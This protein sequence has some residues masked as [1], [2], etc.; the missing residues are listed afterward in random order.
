MIRITD[1]EGKNV[2]GDGRVRHEDFLSAI[3]RALRYLSQHDPDPDFRFFFENLVE[4]SSLKGKALALHCLTR[5]GEKETINLDP[6][7]SKLTAVNPGD[8]KS[9]SKTV[10]KI[11]CTLYKFRQNAR[12]LWHDR[13][14]GHLIKYAILVMDEAFLA[15]RPVYCQ[16]PH[17][18]IPLVRVRLAQFFVAKDLV[19]AASANTTLALPDKFPGIFTCV[20]PFSNVLVEKNPTLDPFSAILEEKPTWWEVAARAAPLPYRYKNELL[21]VVT[22]ASAKPVA[23]KYSILEGGARLHGKIGLG[24]ARSDSMTHLDYRWAGDLTLGVAMGLRPDKYLGQILFVPPAGYMES[25]RPLHINI[26]YFKKFTA[27][28]GRKNKPFDGPVYCLT[29]WS[30]PAL[31][32]NQLFHRLFGSSLA[33]QRKKNKG[34]DRKGQEL[35]APTQDRQSAQA[36]MS[37]KTATEAAG[38]VASVWGKYRSVASIIP[39]SGEMVMSRPI[40]PTDQEWCHLIGHGDGGTETPENFVAGSK[41]CNTEQLAI[42]CALRFDTELHNKL[43]ARVTAYVPPETMTRT[44]PKPGMC[45]E[46]RSF[47]YDQCVDREDIHAIVKFGLKK[48]VPESGGPFKWIKLDMEPPGIPQDLKT[49]RAALITSISAKIKFVLDGGNDISLLDSDIKKLHAWREHKDTY[50]QLSRIADEIVSKIFNMPTVASFIR[51][52]VRLGETIVYDRIYDAQ[53]ESIDR[54]E[55]M[56]IYEDVRAALCYAA[57]RWRA[58]E[59]GRSATATCPHLL[60]AACPHGCRRDARTWSYICVDKERSLTVDNELR[61]GLKHAKALADAEAAGHL[62]PTQQPARMTR[63]EVE[64]KQA[65]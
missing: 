32:K 28:T 7:K 8:D 56:I 41:H 25:P 47:D 38:E 22:T 58:G 44:K 57:D 31:V 15:Q 36:V 55:F 46:G 27:Q 12:V 65:P 2:I 23:W 3:G 18:E 52:Q 62:P 64:T 37:Q 20:D 49:K 13:L 16:E 59:K 35:K 19:K 39:G 1:A 29:N 10:S 30:N 61:I 5:S 11:T 24:I 40:P 48:A 60:G 34:A 63:M 51:Y 53:R 50:N 42:E 26:R 6:D 33:P 4:G 45:I 43:K 17:P 54:N 9:G 21:M 14:M